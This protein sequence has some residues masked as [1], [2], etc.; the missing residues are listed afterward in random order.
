MNKE[1]VQMMAFQLI[2]FAGDAFSHF[3]Q[4]ITHAGNGRFEEAE[5]ELA[6]GKKSLVSAHNAQTELLAEEAEGKEMEYSILMVHAQDHLNSAIMYE[7]LSAEFL[8]L[9]REL[10]ALKGNLTHE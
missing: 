6:E 3:F 1:E 9:Y 7:R 8:K 10:Y 5:Q 2:G 4:S